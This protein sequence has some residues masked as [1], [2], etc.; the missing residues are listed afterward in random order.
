MRHAYLIMA[1]HEP[2][3]LKL[4][5]S[6]LDHSDNDF[7][8]HLDRKSS[9][10]TDEIVS[11]VKQSNLVFVERKRISWGDYSQIDCEMRLLESAIGGNYDYYH[12]LTGVDLPL[13]SN[14]EIDQ[15]F[16]QNN[17]AEFISFDQEANETRDFVRR[18]DGYHFNICYFGNNV[19]LKRAVA[20]LQK[21]LKKVMR[22]VNRHV[23]RSRNYPDLVFMKGSSYFDITHALACHV[24][25]QKD[26]IEK[27]FRYTLCC[28]EVFLHTVAYN[29]PYREKITFSGTRFIDWS[30]HENSPQVLTVEHYDQLIQTEKLFARKFSSAHS[31]ELIQKLYHS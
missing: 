25:S 11:A 7:Y 10:N 16:R 1:H 8:V 9:V 13:K 18:Y 20:I 27:V 19:L 14:E 24:L 15:F 4:L 28:D 6:R 17:G 26:L 30:K 23:R 31:A 2:E 3:I 29:S 12:L 22:V 21:I 5:L